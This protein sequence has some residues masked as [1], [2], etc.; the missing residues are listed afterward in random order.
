MEKMISKKIIKYSLVLS[1]VFILLFFYVK[2]SPYKYDEIVSEKFLSP[3][4][5]H[6][7]GTDYIGRD[8]MVRICFAIINTLI[9]AVS[10]IVFNVFLGGFL[11]IYAGH[12]GG[13]TQKIFLTIINIIDGVPLFLVATTMLIFLNSIMSNLSI[14]GI[15]ITL[16]LTSWTRISRVAL[17]QTTKIKNTEYVYYAIK[18]GATFKH[19]FKYSESPSI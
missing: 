1:T 12:K 9:I 10:A 14:L 18:N 16:F 19:L 3:S 4:L 11:G 13:K 17:I 6:I 5:K 8:F 2:T 7:L 15:V